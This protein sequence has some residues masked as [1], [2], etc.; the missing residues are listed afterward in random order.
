MSIVRNLNG[1]KS[2]SWGHCSLSVDLTA[3][4]ISAAGGHQRFVPPFGRM[5]QPPARLLSALGLPGGDFII[6]KELSFSVN[7][8]S[9]LSAPAPPSSMR[10]CNK[11]ITEIFR[12]PQKNITRQILSKNIEKKGH[13]R[14]KKLRKM[15][16]KLDVLSYNRI[17]R[18]GSRRTIS[19]VPCLSGGKRI[20]SIRHGLPLCFQSPVW[21]E[22]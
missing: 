19:A 6:L 20:L 16:D 21:D 14:A 8:F 12:N 13:F 22:T 2:P 10:G 15:I 17:R 11:I 7:R 4:E 9:V 18:R 5:K 3:D 1:R